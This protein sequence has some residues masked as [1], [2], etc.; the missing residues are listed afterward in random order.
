MAKPTV[1]YATG[2]RK[3]SAARVFLKSGSG[4]FSVN[5]KALNDFTASAPGRV[6]A[7]SPF[8]VTET[9]NKYD[10]EVTVA[11]GGWSAQLGA[12]RHG[13][14]RALSTIDD[15]KLRPALKAAGM[16][17]RDDRMVERKKYGKHKARKSGQF[18]KR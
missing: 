3:T 12:I 18:S 10:V 14:A 7:V 15:N 17:T 13:V 2:K 16:L 5:G 6:L 11:G 9:Q 8:V 1:Y 4:K